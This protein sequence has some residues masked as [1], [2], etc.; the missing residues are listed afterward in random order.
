MNV[1][2]GGFLYHVSY[3]FQFFITSHLSNFYQVP[4]QYFGLLNQ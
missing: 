4:L 3:I 1:E 2:S